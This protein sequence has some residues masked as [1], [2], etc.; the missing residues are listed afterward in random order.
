MGE[1]QGFEI[2]F[3][4]LDAARIAQKHMKEGARRA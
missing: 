3:Q 1:R 2:K 4:N